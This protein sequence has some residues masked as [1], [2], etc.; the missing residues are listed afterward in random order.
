[1]RHVRRERQAFGRQR[2]MV[3]KVEAFQAATQFVGQVAML[4]KKGFAIDYLAS[5]GCLHVRF[6]SSGQLRSSAH[7]SMRFWWHDEALVG[8]DSWGL[9]GGVE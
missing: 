7:G 5:F 9:P 3:N 8:F 1:M 4:E 6:E 2:C